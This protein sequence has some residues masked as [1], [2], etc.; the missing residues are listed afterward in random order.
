MADGRADHDSDR[1]TGE[2]EWQMTKS[3]AS[4]PSPSIRLQ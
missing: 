1:D 2:T 4:M 3:K